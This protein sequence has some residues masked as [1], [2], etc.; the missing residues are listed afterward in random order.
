MIT[1]G[2]GMIPICIHQNKLYLLCGIENNDKVSDLGGRIDA[3]EKIKECAAREFYEESVGLL[4]PYDRLVQSKVYRRVKIGYDKNY[5][6]LIIKTNYK[7]IE[8]KYR[9]LITYVKENNCKMNNKLDFKKYKIQ[10]LYD[11]KTYPEG[12]FEF[13]ELK[14]ISLDDLKNN[15]YKLRNRFKLLLNKL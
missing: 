7:N 11:T 6:S 12:F 10:D 9:E 2:C 14:W 1:T 8:D 4:L 5:I 3:G 13:K 15:K